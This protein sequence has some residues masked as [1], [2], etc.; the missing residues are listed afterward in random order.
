LKYADIRRL[1]KLVES[2]DIAEL[3]IEQGDGKVRIMKIAPPAN[4]ASASIP[5]FIPVPIG[6]PAGMPIAAPPVSSTA[7][8]SAAPGVGIEPSAPAK[9]LLEVQSPMVGTFYRA[10][11]PEAP[12]YVQVGDRVRPG[13]V[14]C[15]IEAMKLMNEIESEYSGTVVEILV[16]NAQPV[17]FGHILFRIDPS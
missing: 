2:S 11:A 7:A 17:E 6:F 3:E 8:T 13:Q 9:K 4:T 1:V 15:I 16:E 5:Q 12:L 10:P 14:L